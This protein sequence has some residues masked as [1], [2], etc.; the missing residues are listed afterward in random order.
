MSWTFSRTTLFLN[1]MMMV[2][3]YARSIYCGCVV[4]PSS[5]L[6][7]EACCC[8]SPINAHCQVLRSVLRSFSNV[9]HGT[10]LF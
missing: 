5:F 1:I 4:V 3:R 7:L 9:W 2:A 8:M 10:R 6:L